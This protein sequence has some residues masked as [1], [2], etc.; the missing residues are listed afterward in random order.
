MFKLFARRS[1]LVGFNS[2]KSF[3][4]VL[5]L[6]CQLQLQAESF[7][8]EGQPDLGEALNK[9]QTIP[10]FELLAKALSPSVV[11]ISVETKEEEQE[12]NNELP[13]LFK[14]PEGQGQSLGSGFIVN[15]EGLIVTNY[16]VVEKAE[17]IIV[18]LLDDRKEYEA[19]L[20]GKDD[21]TDLA[22]IKIESDK[23]LNPV[24]I[25][26][27]DQ[28][29]VGEWV[30]AIGNQFQLGQTVTAGIVSAKSRKVRSQSNSPYDDFIQTD[31]SINPGSSG[32]PLFNSRGQVIGI[33][34]AIFSPGRSQFGGTG[35][36]IGIGFAI[37]MNLA[38]TILEQ[39]KNE[40][41]VTRG[42]LGVIIQNIDED[43]AEAIGL[44]DAKGALVSEIVP[45]SP[46][47]KAGFKTKDIILEYDG[48]PII[49]H[50]DLP[51]VVAN[52][53]LGTTVKV[54]VLRDGKIIAL[55]PTI[56]ELKDDF[57]V[58][59]EIQAEE[60]EVKPNKL[61]L[62]VEEL[63]QLLAK[64]LKIDLSEGI[65]VTNLETESVA[66]KAGVSVGDI[67]IEINNKTIKNITEF[68][69]IV[70]GLPTNKPILLLVKTKVK[71]QLTARFLTLKIPEKDK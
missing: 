13:P 9:T 56:V 44:K 36:N 71:K 11:N 64:S 38:K 61:G 8:K 29:E 19:K 21:K 23:K 16:H 14:K 6:G 22:L 25:G 67:I 12:A 40:G 28:L 41:K 31:A 48:R 26:D 70:D 66:A 37:P 24:F 7:L 52:T 33:N 68:N 18:R 53:K 34:T 57:F 4:L 32:G 27:S 69:K 47:E 10:H 55:N 63:N 3:I 51:L 1:S 58:P 15:P 5:L 45:K 20:L 43:M 54:N 62:V 39:L 42:V 2:I 59:L 17:K 46:A 35:F 50:D 60:T 49:E 30:M 65:I